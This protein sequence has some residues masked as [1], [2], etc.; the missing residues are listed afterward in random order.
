MRKPHSTRRADPTAPIWLYGRHAVAAALANPKRHQHK[1]LATKNALDW[2]ADQGHPIPIE[3]VKPEV[4]DRALPNGAVHQGLAISVNPLKDYS[5]GDIEPEAGP[6]LVL[7]Q[8]TDPQNIGALFR[9]GAAFGAT[10]IVA[11]D[12]RTPPL[13]GALTKAA[14]GA[15][16]TV[17]MVRVVNIARALDNLK[18][19]GFQIA[20]LA[21]EAATPLPEFTPDAPIALVLGAEGSGLRPLVRE[22]CDT[23]L[24]IPISPHVES[25]NVATAAGV[26]LYALTHG[27][28]ST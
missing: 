4:I 9:I 3:P 23:L 25:L 22:G 1:L 19:R 13:S 18:S 11:Q 24:S 10:A 26:A 21:G 27:S 12:R 7:D 8:V 14:A 28:G 17:P 16:E 2:L 6:V 15:V 5:I 20:G